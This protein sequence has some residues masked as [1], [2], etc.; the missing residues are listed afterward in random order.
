[1]LQSSNSGGVGEDMKT[2]PTDPLEAALDIPLLDIYWWFYIFIYEQD[3]NN[4]PETPMPA[5]MEVSKDRAFQLGVPQ[6]SSWST[7]SWP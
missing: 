1:M 5:G 2:T 3:S 6:E 7:T 4:S